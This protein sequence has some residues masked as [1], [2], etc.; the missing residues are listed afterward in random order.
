[1]LHYFNKFKVVQGHKLI[2]ASRSSFFDELFQYRQS[3]GLNN[4]I[5]L[6]SIQAADFKIVLKF[7]YTNDHSGINE[8]NIARIYSAGLKNKIVK[9]KK[10]KFQRKRTA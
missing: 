10:L 3:L 4:E 6:K 1:M 2:I 5:M 9:F 7:L 8:Q